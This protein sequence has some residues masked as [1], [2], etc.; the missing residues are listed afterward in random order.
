MKWHSLRLLQFALALI[1]LILI[2]CADTQRA[3]EYPLPKLGDA[4]IVAANFFDYETE[5]EYQFEVP[6]DRLPSIYAALEPAVVDP[7]P[8]EWQV[9]GDLKFTLR[10]GRSF[11]V[12]LY[13]LYADKPGAFSAGETWDQRIYYRGGS[14]PQLLDALRDARDAAS[15]Q[16]DLKTEKAPQ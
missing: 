8:A 11:Q 4:R 13:Q 10:D 9:L 1:H 15:K 12:Y 14:S 16:K 6:H 2:G 7:D 5:E 3:T